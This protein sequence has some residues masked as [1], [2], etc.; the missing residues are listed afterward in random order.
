MFARP[1]TFQQRLPWIL[2]A[3]VL[4]RLATLAIFPLFDDTESRY[5]EIGRKMLETANWITPWYDYG[6]PF[7]AKPPLSIWGTAAGMALFGIN[8]FGAR[9][10]AFLFSAGMALLTWQLARQR[11]GREAALLGLAILSS[12]AMFF[13]CS[14]AVMTDAAFAFTVTLVMVAFWRTMNGEASWR[15]VFFAGLGIGLLAK[16]PIVGILTFIPIGLWMLLRRNWREMWDRLPWITGTGL[17]LVIGLPWYVLAEMRTPGFLQ[18]FIVGEHFS[19]FF[20]SGWK[21]DRYGYAHAHLLGTIWLYWLGGAMPWS[22][23]WL[24]HVVRH[25]GAWKERLREADGWILFLVLWGITPMLFF[26]VSRNI[27]TPYILPGMPALALL[28]VEC[29]SPAAPRRE[30]L[31][32][33]VAIVPAM[34]VVLAV[35]A[36]LHPEKTDFMTQK[37]LAQAYM[38]HRSEPGSQLAYFRH[39]YYSAEFYSHGAAKQIHSYA[40]MDALLANPSRDFLVMDKT[41]VPYLPATVASRFDVL[42]SYGDMTLLQEKPQ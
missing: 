1:A 36:L 6:V 19:R 33:L 31:A 9:I 42:G 28:V 14:G 13:F 20:V 34:A 15:Y 16:G 35:A 18:Y 27:T 38:V 22:L 4:V 26:T 23:V 25:A 11:K 17:M 3:L 24:G 8:E 10:S 2:V 37:R 32:W 40:D 39:R 30:W 7:W 12:T 5:G 29:L 21:G 41:W